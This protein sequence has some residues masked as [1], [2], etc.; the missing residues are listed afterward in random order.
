M[1][2]ERAVGLVPQELRDRGHAVRL[3]DRELG[4]RVVGR[5]LPYQRDVGAV[6]RG[7]DLQVPLRL[8]HLLREPRRRGMRDGIV[9]VHEVE[10][11]AHRH[12]VLLYR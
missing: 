4:E 8:E 7:D 11:L 6:Q 10:V 12:F 2:S 3:L 9:H 5:V 1:T